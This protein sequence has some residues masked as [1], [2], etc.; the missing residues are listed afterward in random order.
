MM[1]P[2]PSRTRAPLHARGD[3]EPDRRR[4]EPRVRVGSSVGHWFICGR[5]QSSELTSCGF[6]D[7]LPRGSR[8]CSCEAV[9]GRARD[10]GARS[11]VG[12]RLARHVTMRV[13]CDRERGIVGPREARAARA[14][15]RTS[16]ELAHYACVELTVIRGATS[17]SPLAR[18]C[19]VAEPWE[20]LWGMRQV[21]RTVA[22]V[23]RDSEGG[24]ATNR[25]CAGAAAC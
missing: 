1:R 10:G 22:F 5:P 21:S 2:A 9:V 18:D 25:H 16:G 3:A 4:L 19:A 14:A 24:L 7:P 20:G 6:D 8:A 15:V 13:D 23:A 12:R 17:S 11:H